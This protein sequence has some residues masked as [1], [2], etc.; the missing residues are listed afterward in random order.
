LQRSARKRLCPPIVSL[1]NAANNCCAQE[2]DVSEL[3][4]LSK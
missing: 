4:V 3:N 1:P 2:E